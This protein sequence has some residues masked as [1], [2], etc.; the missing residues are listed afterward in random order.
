MTGGK[1]VL[2]ADEFGILTSMLMTL[3][4]ETYVETTGR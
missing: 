1:R 4:P 3:E 2:S